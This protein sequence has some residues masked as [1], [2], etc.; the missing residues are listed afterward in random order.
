VR[1]HIETPLPIAPSVFWQRLFFCEEFNA[2][3]H[4]ELGF[5]HY[6]VVSEQTLADGCVE[7]V[8]E[9]EPPLHAPEIVQRKLGAALRIT[10]RGLF[11]PRTERYSFTHV[12]ALAVGTTRI[13]GSIHVEPRPSGLLHIVDVDIS[14]SA[15]GLGSLIERAIE[16]SVRESYRVMARYAQGFLAEHGLLASAAG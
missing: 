4:R 14:V 15:F 2:G 7:R 11:D 6:A 1:V 10:E 5:A 12:P 13:A 16:K 8:L 9:T 3:L